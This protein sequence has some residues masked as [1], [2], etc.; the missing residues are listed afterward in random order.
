MKPTSQQNKPTGHRRGQNGRIR[1]NGGTL[2]V[3]GYLVGR[4]DGICLNVEDQRDGQLVK[5]WADGDFEVGEVFEDL[6][7]ILAVRSSGVRVGIPTS[8]VTC[9]RGFLALWV[10]DGSMRV[11][12]DGRGRSWLVDGFNLDRDG[13]VDTDALLQFGKHAPEVA[14]LTA[15][16]R[17]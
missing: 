15:L 8:E 12:I 11:R 3:S 16:M 2:K 4:D 7:G 14:R 17:A 10:S 5:V 13:W 1:S 9:L 6:Q